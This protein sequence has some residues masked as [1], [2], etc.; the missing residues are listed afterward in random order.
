MA[1]LL[2]V[3]HTGRLSYADAEAIVASLATLYDA[4]TT[5]R[6]E[7]GQ[8]EWPD[9]APPREQYDPPE[10]QRVAIHYTRWLAQ[11]TQRTQ[12]RQEQYD[13]GLDRRRRRS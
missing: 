6:A 10:A 12:A 13:A 2:Y 11:R 4:T 1:V 5:P 8:P 9:E 3:V 7:L